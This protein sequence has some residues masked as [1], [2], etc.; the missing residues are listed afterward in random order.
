MAY[1]LPNI[2]KDLSAHQKRM[3]ELAEQISALEAENV[4]AKDWTLMGEAT[5]RS[6]PKNSLL[7]EDLDFERAAKAVP[8]ITET[9]TKTLEDRIKARILEVRM[10]PCL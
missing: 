7:E 8:V 9:T 3:A 2:A 10:S 4:G 1:I 5:S 6:R